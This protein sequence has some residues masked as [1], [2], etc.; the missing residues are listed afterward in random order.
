MEFG[1]DPAKNVVNFP[2]SKV[3]YFKKA[4][5]AIKAQKELYEAKAGMLECKDDVQDT[6]DDYKCELQEEIKRLN[7][8]LAELEGSA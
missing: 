8:R 6:A 1:P 3:S 4:V 5:K 7:E 2:W